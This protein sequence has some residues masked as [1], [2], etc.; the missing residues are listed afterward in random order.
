MPSKD[1][2]V[3]L[4]SGFL[5]VLSE[6]LDID[7]TIKKLN[8]SKEDARAIL[9]DLIDRKKAPHAVK[10][11]VPRKSGP[12]EIYVDG[13]SRGNPGKAGAGAVIRDLDGNVLRKLKSYLGVTTNNAAEYRALI[14]ALE[15]ARSMHIADIKVFADSDL[16]VKQLNGVYKV[17]S[18][19]LLPL[20]AKA[21]ELREGFRSFKIAHI[22]REK[23][24]LADSLANEAIDA[25]GG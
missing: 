7:L 16:M 11:G 18:T 3:D 6:T 17:R 12:C 4:T 8:I 2:L 15:A 21:V 24:S 22:Y 9:K 1:S 19:D 5:E 13:A 20:F 23:N 10:E 14:M 25:Q